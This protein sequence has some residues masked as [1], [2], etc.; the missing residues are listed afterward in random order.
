M[1]VS[2]NISPKPVMRKFCTLFCPL[3]GVGVGEEGIEQN[4]MCHLPTSGGKAAS[5]WTCLAAL[6]RLHPHPGSRTEMRGVQ[7]GERDSV[8]HLILFQARGIMFWEEAMEK[9]LVSQR[10]EDTAG[11]IN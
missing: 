5:T 3:L 10:L 1:C 6:F 7:C 8:R 11:E 2:I 4:E 9:S